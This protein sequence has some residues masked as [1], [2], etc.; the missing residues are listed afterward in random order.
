MFLC[1]FTPW[2][3]KALATPETWNRIGK[4]F[5]LENGKKEVS[6]REPS[7]IG[8]EKK[9]TRTELS[10]IYWLNREIK[11]GTNALRSLSRFLREIFA[12]FPGYRIGLSPRFGR[13]APL[14]LERFERQLG[15]NRCA[16]CQ[17]ITGSICSISGGQSDAADPL[18]WT[19]IALKLGGGNTANSI[20]PAQRRFFKRNGKTERGQA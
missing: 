13:R 10:Q 6:D 16:L 14:L 11:R 4:S 20:Y 8:S 2:S 17:N 5:S 12:L 9:L 3:Y 19:T 15:R 7:H 18:C 1:R